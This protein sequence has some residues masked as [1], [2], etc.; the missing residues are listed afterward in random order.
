MKTFCLR[1]DQLDSKKK[2]IAPKLKLNE[3]VSQHDIWLQYNKDY[4]TN[5]V[6]DIFMT[7]HV[8]PGNQEGIV[9]TEVPASLRIS[10]GS[11]HNIMVRKTS[12][13]Y[14]QQADLPCIAY[15][16]GDSKLCIQNTL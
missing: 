4:K 13:F 6:E 2:V 5:T 16:L 12:T 15:N 11:E 3:C 8:S 7:I 14:Q 10:K 1:L 9:Q